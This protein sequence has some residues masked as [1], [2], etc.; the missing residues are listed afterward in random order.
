MMKPMDGSPKPIARQRVEGRTDI[1]RVASAARVAIRRT[2]VVL[3][4]E[5]IV[6]GH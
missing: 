1:V 2:L 5:Q 6:E 3:L 4:L